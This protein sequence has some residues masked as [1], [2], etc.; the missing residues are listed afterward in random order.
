MGEKKE[1]MRE[2]RAGE[3]SPFS[4]WRRYKGKESQLLY[5]ESVTAGKKE[6]QVRNPLF[7]SCM[8]SNKPFFFK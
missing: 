6:T 7:S 4:K 8:A 5:R 2:V 1:R 3:K